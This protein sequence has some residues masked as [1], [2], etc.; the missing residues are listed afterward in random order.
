MAKSPGRRYATANELAADLR[1]YLAGEPIAARPIGYGERLWRWCRHH[2]LASGLFVALV[3]GAGAG[4]AYL[5]SLSSYF[6]RETALDS[7]RMEAD[8]MEQVNSYYSDIIDRIDQKAVNVTHEYML[9]KNT[10]PLPA[11]FTIDSARRIRE[12]QSGLK[13]RL[14]GRNPFRPENAPQ[15]AFQSEA[16][17]VLTGRLRDVPPSPAVLEYHRFVTVDEQPFLLYARGQL[18]KESCVKCHNGHNQSP[19]KDWKEGDLV[20]VLLITRPLD[21]DIERTRSGLRSAFVVMGATAGIL[22]AGA[23]F[24]AMRSRRRS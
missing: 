6:V 13:V 15:D 17:D 8:I 3:L 23:L 24:V 18:M 2:P 4:L 7:A 19:K 22:A 9:R 12:S 5:T 11:T 20:G 21:R 16:L 1:R 14:Y 10:L